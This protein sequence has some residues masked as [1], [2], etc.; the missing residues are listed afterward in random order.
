MRLAEII[1]RGRAIYLNGTRPLRVALHRPRLPL[2]QSASAGKIIDD[3]RTRGAAITSLQALGLE[4]SQAVFDRALTLLTSNQDNQIQSPERKSFLR[5][6]TSAS[7]LKNPEIYDWGLNHHLLDIVETYLQVPIRYL[8]CIC[9]CDLADGDLSE[10]R[11]FHI[12]GEDA[13]IVKIIVYLN[14]VGPDDGPFE[15]VPKNLNPTVSDLGSRYYQRVPDDLLARHT[16]KSEWV[17]ATGPAGTVVF[18]D[19]CNVFHK[20]RLSVKSDRNACFFTYCSATPLR[21]DF[22]ALNEHNLVLAQ[23]KGLDDRQRKIASPIR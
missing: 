7:M 14:D 12:D 2:L 13:A 18:V 10:T 4:N 5:I 11:L 8:G 20:G 21:P 3:L 9:R 23:A 16:P 17:A 22:C 19:T 15:F 6:L 1:N